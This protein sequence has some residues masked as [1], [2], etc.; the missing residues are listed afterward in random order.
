EREE[1]KKQDQ[2]AKQ[3][4]DKIKKEK[5]ELEKLRKE[6]PKKEK[7]KKIKKEKLSKKELKEKAQATAY[8]G[9]GGIDP[10]PEFL[11]PIREVALLLKQHPEVKPVRIEGHTD[12]TGSHTL[13][14]A[15]SLRR[16]EAVKEILIREGVDPSRIV[17]AGFNADRPVAPNITR[18][19][20]QLNRR[21]EIFIG[22]K[23]KKRERHRIKEKEL[24]K[25]IHTTAYFSVG[26]NH[27][28]QESTQWIRK[29]AALLREHPEIKEI[30]VEGHTD[31]I[32]D[33]SKNVD[34][35]L[36]R[37][38]AVKEILVREGIDPSRIMTFGFNADRP[39]AADNTPSERQ[40]NR[41]VEIM[42]GDY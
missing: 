39:V 35:S 23:E 17:T 2:E 30:A 26:A 24:R 1:L 36:Q 13:N 33:R 19:E 14:L 7:A 28:S 4:A 27:P 15:L 10:T 18:R 5:A 38:E 12:N 6:A 8:F 34:L 42:V 31:N 16:A 11:G 37:A 32:G 3:L 40:L 9:V 21:V 29:A 22:D 41:R 25:N 20:R